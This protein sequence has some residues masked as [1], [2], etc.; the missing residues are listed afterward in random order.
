[1]FAASID[2][3]PQRPISSRYHSAR[4]LRMVF[5]G[6]NCCAIGT[7]SFSFRQNAY[8]CDSSFWAM[9]YVLQNQMNTISV[10]QYITVNM[11]MSYPQ[12]GQILK[13]QGLYWGLHS[14][15]RLAIIDTRSII[16]SFHMFAAWQFTFQL[17]V[18]LLQQLG[19]GF[20]GVRNFGNLTMARIST[21]I[22][23]F[24]HSTLLSFRAPS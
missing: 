10:F 2:Q 6:H 17:A 19:F 22:S 13:V 24:S 15:L 14:S 7:F 9:P 12:T 1:M 16:C 20:G 11:T 5:Q 4:R 23:R 8:L 3:S 21:S 18:N